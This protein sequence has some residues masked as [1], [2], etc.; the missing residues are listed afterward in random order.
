MTTINLNNMNESDKEA[1]D[2]LMKFE[3]V[4]EFYETKLKSYL[5]TVK[6][7]KE[8]TRD[9][10]YSVKYD[11]SILMCNEC[12]MIRTNNTKACVCG[13]YKSR[14]IFTDDVLYFTSKVL[15]VQHPI[16]KNVMSDIEENCK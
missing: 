12:N 15:S 3:S 2:E 9:A 10:I 16:L 5:N 4:L 8:Q 13:S 6:T 1:I 7:A 11:N 14:T